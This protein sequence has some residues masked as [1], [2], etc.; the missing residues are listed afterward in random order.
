MENN[1]IIT[2]IC[3]S[4]FVMGYLIATIN[5]IYITKNEVKNPK[6]FKMP[7][8]KKEEKVPERKET[9]E[10]ARANHFYQ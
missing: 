4:L 2:F 5:A 8:F 6:K 10:E 1:F 7:K 9:E 3:I